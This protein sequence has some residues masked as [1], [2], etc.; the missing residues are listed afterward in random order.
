MIC[1]LEGIRDFIEANLLFGGIDDSG[2][3]DPLNDHPHEEY[4]AEFE[5]VMLHLSVA[6]AQSEH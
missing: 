1:L 2:V 5:V 3:L 6:L 4:A